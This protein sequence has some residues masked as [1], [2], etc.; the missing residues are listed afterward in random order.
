MKKVILLFTVFITL[1]FQCEE[2][3]ETSAINEY[4]LDLSGFLQK[5]YNLGDTIHIKRDF[6]AMLPLKSK[7]LYDNTGLVMNFKMVLLKIRA[8]FGPIDS[9]FT[10][11]DLIIENGNIEEHTIKDD[12]S[13]TLTFGCDSLACKFDL[14]LTPK[15]KGIYCLGSVGFGSFGSFDF[16]QDNRLEIILSTSSNNYSD[17]VKSPNNNL[18]IET[19]NNRLTISDPASKNDF[20]F[21]EVK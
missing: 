18:W 9:G 11:F 6:D 10:F 1:G 2:P 14:K 8:D 16:C 7:I 20:Y 3:C 5:Q 21:F 17:L 4:E 15:N 19:G 12:V 13:R